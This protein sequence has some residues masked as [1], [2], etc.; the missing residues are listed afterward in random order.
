[1]QHLT[2]IDDKELNY[3]RHQARHTH[4][5]L[6]AQ[7]QNPQTGPFLSRQKGKGLE[8]EDQRFYEPGDD[9]RHMNWQATARYQRLVTKIFREE[10]QARLLLVI[11][12]SSNML[13]GSQ[14]LKAAIAARIACA[15][16]FYATN[17]QIQ[18]DIAVYDH[19]LT[20]F[21][22]IKHDNQ[23]F[24]FLSFIKT[25]TKPPTK[26]APVIATKTLLQ[27]IDN[28][29]LTGD[30]IYFIGDFLSWHKDTSKT[31]TVLRNKYALNAIQVYD[32]LEEN[33]PECG[34]LRVGDASHHR[35]AVINTH[36]RA[37]REHLNKKMQQRQQEIA[38][39]FK[40]SGIPLLRIGTHETPLQRLFELRNAS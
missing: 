8:L 11:D 30:S 37:L 15:L 10:R 26:Q 23:L 29:Q 16:A 6:H 36:N 5:R 31:L 40:Q 18:L 20:F 13:F 25:Q 19:Q 2:L 28:H 33:L 27:Q 38:A 39:L 21:P 1:M 3:I 17:R 4:L 35:T 32:P 24:P 9:I 12:R 14:Q 22:T 7:E 34:R